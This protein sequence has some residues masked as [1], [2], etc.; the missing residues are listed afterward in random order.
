MVTEIT[1][2]LSAPLVT[3]GT[4][5]SAFVYRKQNSASALD[6][7]IKIIQLWVIVARFLD[8]SACPRKVD[9]GLEWGGRFLRKIEIRNDAFLSVGSCECDL[10]L[11]PILCLLAGFD[12][13]IQ[14]GLLIRIEVLVRLIHDF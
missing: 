4:L 9:Y 13:C 3:V 10:F 7:K 2:V 6:N 12:D 11:F 8:D 1:G 5:I 14:W